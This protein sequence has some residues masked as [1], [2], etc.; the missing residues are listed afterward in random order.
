MDNKQSSKEILY[1]YHP[2]S[3]KSLKMLEIV[4]QNRLRNIKII[5]AENLDPKVEK[6]IKTVPSLVDGDKIITKEEDILSY[7]KALT[8]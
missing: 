3:P 4:I 6:T 5:S 7:I 1:I 2:Q 8:T